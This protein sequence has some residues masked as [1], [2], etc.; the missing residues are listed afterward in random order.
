MTTRETRRPA[1]DAAIVLGGLLALGV[2]VGVF[3]IVTTPIPDFAIFGAEFTATWQKL[4]AGLWSLA[5]LIAVGFF[6]HGIL[7]MTQG[8]CPAPRGRSKSEREAVNAAIALG[9]LIAGVVV[10]G[11]FI[12]VFGS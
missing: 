8:S 4:G 6:G 5:V 9:G 11:V 12:R 2:I 1:P 10:V 7:G 3:I